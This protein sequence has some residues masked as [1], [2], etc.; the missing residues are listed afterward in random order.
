MIQ[1]VNTSAGFFNEQYCQGNQTDF[2]A[3]KEREARMK[4]CQ[5]QRDFVAPKAVW[6]HC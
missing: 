2:V 6:S 5:L 3:A 1:K 4:V